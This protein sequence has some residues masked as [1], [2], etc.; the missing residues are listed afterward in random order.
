MAARVLWAHEAAGSNPVSRTRSGRGVNSSVPVC[1]A[2]GVGAN[3]ADLTSNSLR[4][5]PTAQ[6]YIAC[7]FESCFLQAGK[8]R[9]GNATDSQ[10]VS[11]WGNPPHARLA[12][13]RYSLSHTG[14]AYSDQD[15][16]HALLTRR[17]WVRIP[18]PAPHAGVAQTGKSIKTAVQT[19]TRC[20][21]TGYRPEIKEVIAA[22]N[23]FPPFIV[24]TYEEVQNYAE[25]NN[26]ARSFRRTQR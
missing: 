3:P 24:Q 6:A 19:C 21:T 20:H 1:H 23:H 13:R 10:S 26:T 11:S 4:R 2:G 25:N 18:S 7:R 16:V 14:R 5:A 15:S 8:W 9:N 17:L 12:R 22:G